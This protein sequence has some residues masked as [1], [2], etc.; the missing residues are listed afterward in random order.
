M[1][2]KKISVK[3]KE[4]PQ[5]EEKKVKKSRMKIPKTLL[6]VHHT[7]SI[8]YFPSEINCFAYNNSLNLLVIGRKQPCIEI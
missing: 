3:S 5:E 6:S 4:I 7:Q 2:E 1:Q 8:P